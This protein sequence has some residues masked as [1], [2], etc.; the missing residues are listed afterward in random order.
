MEKG[1]V[2]LEVKMSEDLQAAALYIKDADGRIWKDDRFNPC[3]KAKGKLFPVFFNVEFGWRL[4][5]G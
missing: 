4:G 1:L 5:L 2:K 3:R